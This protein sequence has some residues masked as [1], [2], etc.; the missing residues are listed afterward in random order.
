M[1]AKINSENSSK[2]PSKHY[3]QLK[4]QLLP[5]K[6]T[7]SLLAMQLLPVIITIENVPRSSAIWR[8][9]YPLY[10]IEN[11][12]DKIFQLKTY[13]SANTIFTGA[14]LVHLLHILRENFKA[15]ILI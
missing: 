2:I 6:I 4:H 5:E 3:S 8:S 11:D 12:R 13:R 14:A 1:N 7:R 15:R 10:P 9:A